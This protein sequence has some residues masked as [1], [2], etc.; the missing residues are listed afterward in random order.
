MSMPSLM[1]RYTNRFLL[2]HFNDDQLRRYEAMRRNKFKKET[3]RR[4]VNQTLSQSVPPSV[5]I[6]ISGYTKLLVGLLI[7][8]ARDVQEQ[9]AAVAAAAYPS[10]PSRPQSSRPATKNQPNGAST[11]ENALQSS[12]FASTAT[13]SNHGP[14]AGPSF[15]SQNAH[16]DTDSDPDRPPELNHNDIFGTMSS[17]PQPPTPSLPPDLP[18]NG[19]KP[20]PSPSRQTSALVRDNSISRS[21]PPSRRPPSRDFEEQAEKK[22]TRDLGPLLPDHLREAFRRHKR[23]GEC[24]GI[25]QGGL[26]LMGIGVQGTFAGGRGRGRRLFR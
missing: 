12:S 24:A 8:R 4:I 25:G 13:L 23:N 19:L 10:P 7:E 26:S 1:P 2:E 11:Q 6:G 16:Q 14:S 15:D 18:A 9:N 20:L 22:D 17:P 5:V 21:P 3:V